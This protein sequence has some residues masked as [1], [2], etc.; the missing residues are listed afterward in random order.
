MPDWGQDERRV[1]AAKEEALKISGVH[2]VYLGLRY[3]D[4][5]PTDELA[6]CVIVRRKKPFE[7]VAPSERVPR[8]IAGIP[9]DVL[10]G[11]PPRRLQADDPA[12]P[13]EAQ[14]PT[15]DNEEYSQVRGGIPVVG[16]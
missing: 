8:E 1:E 3:R 4:A 14:L 16:A 7:E 2:T 5:R 11:D 12:K 6:L 10:E 9:T 15:F 13:T